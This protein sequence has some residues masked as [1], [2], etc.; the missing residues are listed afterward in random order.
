MIEC[1]ICYNNN[2]ELYDIHT[3]CIHSEKICSTCYMK[4]HVCPICRIDLYTL[5]EIMYYLVNISYKK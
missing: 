5:D 1:C 2:I 3:N 4:I